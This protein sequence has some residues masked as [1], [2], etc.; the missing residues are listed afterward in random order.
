[1]PEWRRKYYFIERLHLGLLHRLI[2]RFSGNVKHAVI[3]TI[4]ISILIG[5]SDTSSDLGRCIFYITQ[6]FI[7]RAIAVLL[8]DYVPGLIVF[9]HHW[10]SEEWKQSTKK[11][12]I[13]AIFA[14]TLQ[15]F[16]LL[17]T[18]IMWLLEIGCQQK[19]KLARLSTILHGCVEAPMQLVI[20]LCAYSWAIIP[21]PWME[22]TTII[23]SN[24]NYLYLGQIA[25]AAF[26]LKCLGIVKGAGESFETRSTED[27]LQVY[28]WIN[29]LYLF[30]SV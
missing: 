3:T 16:S 29:T 20:L 23:D 5:T 7:L 14:L 22:S 6:G 21:L 15:P 11:L 13:L 26:I 27:K 28:S 8:C 10:T 12:K 17:I 4:I 25:V 18:N 19:H 24:N 2:L 9:A 1:M 30:D